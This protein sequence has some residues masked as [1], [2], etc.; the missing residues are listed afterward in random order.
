MFKHCVWY[1]LKKKHPINK[2]ILEY[3]KV[4]GTPIFPAHITIQHSLNILEAKELYEKYKDAK[5]PEFTPCGI[6]AMNT[7]YLDDKFFFSIE[8]PLQINGVRVQNIHLSL[9]YKFNLPFTAME[10]GYVNIEK[11]NTIKPDDLSICIVD[12][13]SSD[14]SDWS[15]YT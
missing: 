2:Y 5:I 12:C 6:P 11:M 14:V 7:T 15:I 13:S 4:F 1:V 10:I 8:Q 9:A 3:A